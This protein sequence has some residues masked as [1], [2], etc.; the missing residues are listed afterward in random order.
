MEDPYRVAD[1]ATI[2]VAYQHKTPPAD[3]YGEMERASLYVHGFARRITSV[4]KQIID[5][6]G[7]AD[8]YWDL[9]QLDQ[10]R[11]YGHLCVDGQP[12]RDIGHELGGMQL[13]L[14]DRDT[15]KS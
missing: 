15:G 14:P 5:P 10:S 11:K 4:M 7:N 2:L 3:P 13:P 1:V 9:W 8:A 6:D 12:D